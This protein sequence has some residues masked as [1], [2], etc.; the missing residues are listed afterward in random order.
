M[1]KI[2]LIIVF[3]LAA[4]LTHAQQDQAQSKTYFELGQ[5]LNFDLNDGDY[6]FKFKKMIFFDQ[7]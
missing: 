5:G 2:S 6:T 7:L 4:V 3:L 1:K